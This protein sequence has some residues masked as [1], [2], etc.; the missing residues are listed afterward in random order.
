VLFCF[1]HVV[2]DGIAGKI[3]HEMLQRNLHASAI[4]NNNTDDPLPLK[5]DIL[6]LPHFTKSTFT[7]PPQDLITYTMSPT[8]ALATL[9]RELRPFSL[10]KA[11]RSWIPIRTNNNIKD[12]LT[13]TRWCLF[14]VDAAR[15]SRVLA[16]CRRH[17]TTLT[18]LL[19][20]LALVEFA[21]RVSPGLADDFSAK[22]YMNMRR[23]IQRGGSGSGIDLEKT[24]FS[25]IMVLNHKFD[26]SLVARLCKLLTAKSK[27]R[28]EYV[29]SYSW[30]G[31]G[32]RRGEG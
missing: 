2:G 21:A 5:G 28:R 27:G 14:H 20:A 4:D 9:W 1:N 10:T 6:Q 3:F 15:A 24:M 19:Q 30:R 22:T 8:W 29:N 16:A 32:R 31:A 25:A 23:F 13:S 12:M 18:G 11:E 17:G 26:Q 7:P